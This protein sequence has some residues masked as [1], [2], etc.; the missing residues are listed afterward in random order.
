M[1]VNP[2]DGFEGMLAT[3]FIQTNLCTF[4]TKGYN[5]W[6]STFNNSTTPFAATDNVNKDNTT[7]I[8]FGTN[9][10]QEVGG[11]RVIAPLESFRGVPVADIEAAAKA[12]EMPA[13]IDVTVDQ[14]GAKRPAS[15]IPGSYDVLAEKQSGI[16]AIATTAADFSLKALGAAKFMVCGAEGAVAVY[17]LGGRKVLAAAVAEG[18]ILDLSTLA[19]GI[20][21]VSL[22]GKAVKVA[23]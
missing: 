15:T 9:A 10:A 21:V 20:Y 12:W 19:A 3:N 1:Q 2:V 16:E 18:G 22:D 5:I 8:V 6:G 4:D 11:T 23:L 7:A 13:D 17:D 14:R